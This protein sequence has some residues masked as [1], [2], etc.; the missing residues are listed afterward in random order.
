MIRTLV[1][2]K[3]LSLILLLFTASYSYSSSNQTVKAPFMWHIKTETSNLYLA[4][5]IHALNSDFYPFSPAYL[6]AFNSVDNLVVEINVNALDAKASKA[7]IDSLTWLPNKMSLETRLKSADI[8][9]LTPFAKAK[10]MNI[11]T[12]LKLRPWI[13]LEMLTSYQLAQTDFQAQLGV[14]QFFIK[15]AQQNNKPILEL[16]TLSEQI[17]AIN[18]AEMSAQV[19]AIS[20]A[21][22]QLEDGQ[23]QLLELA[24]FWQ[25]ADDKGLYQYSQEDL[26]AQPEIAPLMATL[27]DDRNHTMATKIAHYLETGGSYFVMVGAL[28]LAGPNSVQ[29]L[30]KQKGYE[31]IKAEK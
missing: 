29:N 7:F 13:I 14:D 22:S 2:A 17:N 27:L 31:L 25:S 18:G 6:A 3:T 9:K 28:H 24:N 4:G 11:Q 19:A 10:G 21:L 30:L 16:E 1:Q 5:S 20:L 23:E 12:L 8:N 15:K 26:I